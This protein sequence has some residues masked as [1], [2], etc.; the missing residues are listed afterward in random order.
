MEPGGK[1]VFI[2]EKYFADFKAACA[3]S[4]QELVER[5]NQESLDHFRKA[6]SGKR[7]ATEHMGLV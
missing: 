7:F 2:V 4:F 5:R 1:V 6:V 3:Q